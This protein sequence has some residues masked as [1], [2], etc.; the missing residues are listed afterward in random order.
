[1]QITS[2]LV[3][4]GLGLLGATAAFSATNEPTGADAER[5]RVVEVGALATAR[6]AHQASLLPS[7]KV[8]ITGGC[9]GTC[10][11]SLA[12]AELFD[13]ATLAFEAVAPMSRSR[14]SHVAAAL[15][16]GRVLVAGGSTSTGATERAEIYDPATGAFAPTGSMT[17]FRHQHRAVRALDLVDIDHPVVVARHRQVH[18][19]ICGIPQR[20]KMTARNGAEIRAFPRSGR[21]G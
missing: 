6:A 4:A 13:P 21:E 10:D 1:M 20:H 11:G 17:V 3:V 5:F 14:N 16:D 19:F 8:L 12:S 2:A 7:G 18:D 15:P 9:S